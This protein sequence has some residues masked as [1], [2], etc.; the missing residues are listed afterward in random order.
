MAIWTLSAA[1]VT[2]E[3]RSSRKGTLRRALLAAKLAL[4][5]RMY[6]AGIDDGRLGALLAA[7]EQSLRRA[8]AA[9]LPL[10]RLLAGRRE[11]LLR[12]AAAALEDDAPLPGADAEYERARE[13]LAEFQAGT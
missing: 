3:A 2:G 11:L 8:E 6:A 7:S 9:R 1:P 10:G 12:L 5:E 13:A 4:G